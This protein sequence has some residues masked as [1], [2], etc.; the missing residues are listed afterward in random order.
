MAAIPEATEVSAAQCG[1]ATTTMLLRQRHRSARAKGIDEPL[2]PSSSYLQPSQTSVQYHSV[3]VMV[4]AEIGTKNITQ[5]RG[6][7]EHGCYR[8]WR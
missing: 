3:C 7:Q 5:T 1:L 2:S 4:L 8:R 6:R